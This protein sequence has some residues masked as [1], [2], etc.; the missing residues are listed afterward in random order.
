MR[1]LSS[2]EIDAIVNHRELVETLRRAYRSQTIVPSPVRLPID[3]PETPDAS[4]TIS[5]AWTN[6]AAQGHSRRG[7]IGCTISAAL[8][9]GAASGAYLLLSGVDGTPIAILDGVR[10]AA[11]RHTAVHAL[12]CQY[13]AREDCSRLLILGKSPLLPLLVL[14]L[15]TVRD[16]RSVLVAGA[17]GEIVQQLSA[18]PGTDKIVF[19]TTTDLTGAIEGADMICCAEGGLALLTGNPLPEGIHVSVLNPA[20]TLSEALSEDIRLF[21]ADRQDQSA[22]GVAD[23]AA[24]LGEL[25]QGQKAGRRFYG[26][27]TLFAGGDVTGLTD[28]ATAGHIFLRS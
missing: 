9:G 19:G 11:W 21:T 15:V 28:L 17:T 10:L 22:Q 18:L 7:Y 4:L 27:K 13:L 1:V 2:G 20:E 6:F 24:D 5:P 23:L 25:T 3:R 12:A 26:Q 8:E 14:A 16:V